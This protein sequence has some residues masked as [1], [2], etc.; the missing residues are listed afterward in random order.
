MSL[1]ADQIKI[2]QSV[3]TSWSSFLQSSVEITQKRGKPVNQTSDHH[4]QMRRVFPTH[5]AAHIFLRIWRLSLHRFNLS[6]RR[7]Y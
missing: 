6:L 1:P 2:L 3:N 7:I 5:T 4:Q